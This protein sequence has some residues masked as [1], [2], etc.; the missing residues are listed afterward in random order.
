[1]KFLVIITPV[2]EEDNE[3]A[4]PCYFYFDYIVDATEFMNRAIMHGDIVVEI[5]KITA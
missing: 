2:G 1:M 4:T 5:K 3:Y